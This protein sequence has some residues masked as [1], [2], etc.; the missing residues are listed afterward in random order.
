MNNGKLIDAR[1]LPIV[2]LVPR[3]RRKTDKRYRRRIEASIRAV[4]LIEPL[5]VYPLGEQYEI[6]DGCRRYIILLD[7]GVETVP[8]LIWK[9]REAFTGNRMVNRLSSAQEMRMLRKSLEE[10]D[11]KTIANALGMT[12]IRYRLNQGLLKKLNPKVA[13]LFESGKVTKSCATELAHVKLD[14]QEE[15]LQLMESC[16]DHSV[17]FAKGMVLKTPTGKRT[18]TQ[19]QKT[20]WNRAAEKKNDLLKRLHEAE[21]QQEFYSGLYR[22]YTTNLLKL[23]IYARSLVSN[24]RINEYLQEH[25]PD[26]LQLFNEIIDNTEQ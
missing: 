14:R 7:M 12:E 21:Q 26:Q 19:S 11:E 15:I 17:T 5:V 23:V 22:Q 1:D 10:L 8:C 24:M 16:D 3:N 2:K 18:K 20:P 13:R 4:G 9:E 25:Y 6:L